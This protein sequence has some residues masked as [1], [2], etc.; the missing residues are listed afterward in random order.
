MQQFGKYCSSEMMEDPK[1]NRKILEV[2]S[3]EKNLINNQEWSLSRWMNTEVEKAWA[4]E[5]I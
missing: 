1:M 3:G 4:R 2:E 5:C